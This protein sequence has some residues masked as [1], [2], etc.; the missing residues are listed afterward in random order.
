MLLDVGVT[1][2]LMLALSVPL[3]V[4]AWAFLDA[5][6]RPKWVWAFAGRRQVVWMCV[7]GFGVLTV[8]GGLA[9]SGYYLS[10][11]RPELAGTEGGDF[12]VGDLDPI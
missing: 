3:A 6:S 12:G 10:R 4:T 7:I 5:A 1:L 11:V 9:V 8:I 2:M